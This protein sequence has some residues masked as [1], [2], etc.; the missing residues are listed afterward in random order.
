MQFE[1]TRAG[2]FDDTQR[3]PGGFRHDSLL[4]P[5]FVAGFS[6]GAG[7]QAG[8]IEGWHA[9]APGPVRPVPSL[10]QRGL[11][12]GAW[13]AGGQ[14][15]SQ[16]LRLAGNLVLARLLVPEAF[17]LMA[18]ISTLLMTLNL[19]SD[20]GSGTV[21]VQSPRGSDNV[22]LNTAW[23]LQAIR[24]VALWI[25]GLAIAVLLSY[26]Q[27]SHWLTP[28]T[29]YDDARLPL[30]ISVASF[31][32][33]IVGLSSVNAKLA[34]R[35]LNIAAISVIDLVAV[36]VAVVAMSIGAYLTGSIWALIAG[37]LLSAALKSFLSHMFLK[38][39]RARFR[40][41]STAIS[42]LIGKGKWIVA[43]SILGLIA[44]SGDKLLLGGLVDGTTL[45]LYSIALG[46]A[47]IASSTIASV[48]G[49]VIFP[50]FSEV[51][52]DNVEALNQTYRKLQ[53]LVDVFV[54]ILAG[55]V[56][57]AADFIVA[58]LYDARYQG[59]GHILRI[60]AI[61]SIGIRFVV[62]EQIYIAMGR[63][64]LLALAGFPRAVIIVIGVPLG[65]A[66]YKLDGALAAVVLSQ[67]AHWPLAVWFRTK[68][69]L[70]HILN[71]ILLIPSVL[72]G[73]TVGWVALQFVPMVTR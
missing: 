67:F 42:E 18:V 22:F 49:R 26:A 72:A 73:L 12:A 59:V 48:L 32:A 21:I 69:K 20:I 8:F 25:S 31:G 13:V 45:G 39:P 36:A 2:T 1:S 37:S 4:P 10:K 70:N 47:S 5:G 53:Q 61:G 65:Y 51:V 34:E 66:V 27:H 35:N 54:G 3:L 56:F 43:S 55:F 15:M 28:G 16:V 71:D 50:V 52:R 33:V 60:L 11:R 40:L 46:L 7:G 19:F 63:M 38:G 24:G 30:L 57:V 62:A 64:S 29:V 6:C 41:E 9:S 58:I 44:V 14:F 17:G 68:L 23:T